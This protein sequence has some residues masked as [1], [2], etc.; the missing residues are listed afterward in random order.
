[1]K[2]IADQ[3]PAAIAGLIH[4]DRRKNEDEYWAAREQ[5]L[6]QYEGQ[7]IGFA[8]GTVVASGTSPVLVL[9]AAEATGLH[10]FVIQVGA[11]DEPLRVRRITFA[12]DETYSRSCW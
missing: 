6:S 3:L 1:M 5:L 7:W 2:R 10:P 9:H 12:Y 11:E 4:P 8:R